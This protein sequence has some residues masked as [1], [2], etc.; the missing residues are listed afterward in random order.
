MTSSVELL[1]A[2]DRRLLEVVRGQ[3]GQQRLDVLDRV[4][5]VGAHVV[6]DTGL[7]VVGAGAAELLDADVLAGDGLDDVG[8]GDEHVRGLV[9]HDG[10][11]GDGGGVDGATGARAHDERDLRD[12]PGRVDVAAEDLAVEPERDHTLLD[13]RATGVVEPDDGAADLHRE[14]HDLGDLL[15]EDL[16]ER[17]AEDGEVLREDR[18]GAPVDG[19]VAGDDAVAVGPVRV[20]AEGDRAVPG[21]LVHL[22][23]RALVEEHREALAGGL[24]AACVLLLDGPLGAGVRDLADAPL[25]VG[26]L[27]GGGVD[28]DAGVR[29]GDVGSTGGL[30]VGLRH[31]GDSSLDPVP[32]PAA[33]PTDGCGPRHTRAAV[34]A[35]RGARR[36]SARPT[37][38]SPAT[39][40]PWRVV[41]AE[42]QRTG[43]GPPRPGVDHDARGEHRGERPR[44]PPGPR[45]ARLGAARRRA[46]PAR[47]PHLRR[48]GVDIALKWPNDLL[49]P[50]DGDRKVAGILAELTPAGVVVGT[51]VNIDQERAD[52]PVDTATSLRLAGAP[53]VSRERVLT[54]YLV[55][56]AA[57]LRELDDDPYAVRAAYEAACATVGREVVVHLPTS[58]AAGSRDGGRRR[59]QTVPEDRRRSVCRGRRRRRPRPVTSA[60]VQEGAGGAGA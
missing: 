8:T 13:A 30:G 5:L 16:A 47:R 40:G 3:V 60:S 17:P 48:A 9:D 4:L 32:L 58:R 50:A 57:L 45:P 18:D 6:G 59:R 54:A 56:L 38:S 24:L 2:E 34:A 36:R 7:G 53:G 43:R 12:D 41:T 52:L 33:S 42:E 55:R 27:A 10:E 51:G 35:G 46:R 31:G 14:V 1:V 22:D 20:L 29:G 44:A 39:R 19:A 28:V 23:E 26:E 21:V 11:V 37:P 25:E 15:A 49:V